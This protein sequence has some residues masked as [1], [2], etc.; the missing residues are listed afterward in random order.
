VRA[1]VGVLLTLAATVSVA[2]APIAIPVGYA[3]D[4]P[5]ILV[6]QIAWGHL[7]GVRLLAQACQERKDAAAS[8]AYVDWLERQRQP[9]ASVAADLSRYYFGID[10]APMAAIDAALNLTPTLATPES[11]L[12]AAC[13]TLP[14]A[15]ASK[16]HDLDR[17]IDEQR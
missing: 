7:H 16:R 14:E 5:R 15:L 12:A 6:R 10:A 3:F 17:L 1:V 9:I 2:E 4:Q 11:E 8:Q 13:Q